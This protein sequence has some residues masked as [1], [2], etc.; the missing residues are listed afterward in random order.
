MKYGFLPLYMAE[1]MHLQPAVRGAVIGIQP[2]V[3]LAIMPFS[4]MLARRVGLLQS[5]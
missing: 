4:V 5:L 1:R 2:L 3:E